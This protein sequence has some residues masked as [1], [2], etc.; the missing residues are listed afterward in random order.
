MASMVVVTKGHPDL[1]DHQDPLVL[2]GLLKDSNEHQDPLVQGPVGPDLSGNFE[3][4]YAGSAEL[5]S[6]TDY[7]NQNSGVYYDSG[8]GL[9]YV[10][11]PNSPIPIQLE[12]H[13]IEHVIIKLKG[14]PDNHPNVNPPTGD[15]GSGIDR[16][17]ALPV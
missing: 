15:N 10:R 11:D 14:P 6:S 9:N 1:L 8:S 7:S 17:G 5:K 12:D 2:D 16:R 4:T 3:F 13:G